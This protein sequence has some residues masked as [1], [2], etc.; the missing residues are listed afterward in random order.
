LDDFGAGFGS[1]YYLKYLPIDFLKIDGEFI[2]NLPA[3]KTDQLFVKSI[4][5]MVHGLG[6]KTIAEH[7]EDKETV[8]KL[9]ELDVDFAQGFHFG[10]PEPL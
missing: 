9:R 4:N 2:R 8:E 5:E 10:H 7:A 6:H 1:F 3:S